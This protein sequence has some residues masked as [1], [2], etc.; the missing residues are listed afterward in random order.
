[1]Q[2]RVEVTLL[3]SLEKMNNDSAM[4]LI[5]ILLILLSTHVEQTVA[6]TPTGLSGLQRISIST[7]MVH[8]RGS[9]RFAHS[10]VIAE[11]AP[12]KAHGS[13]GLFTTSSPDTKRV[14]PITLEG[15]VKFKVVYVVLESQYQSSLTQACLSINGGNEN[16]AVEAVG[17]L[18]E[19]LRNPVV[20][21]QFKTDVADA[22]I[23]IGSLIFI[24]E[25]ADKVQFAIVML[26]YSVFEII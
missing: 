6:F 7:S 22:N 26:Q 12:V 21:E 23:F 9:I 8:V 17:Y 2:M 4:I 18:L 13:N 5:C 15:K 20:L 24:Q 1:M 11:K 25:L 3:F 16:V 19:E 14:V 10:M